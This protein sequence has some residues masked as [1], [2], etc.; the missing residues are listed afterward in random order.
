MDRTLAAFLMERNALNPVMREA[1]D[2]PENALAGMA[3]AGAAGAVSPFGASEH[4]LR[5]LAHLLGGDSSQYGIKS[6]EI[7]DRL[8]E[9][10]QEY[11][12]IAGATSGMV[13]VPIGGAAALGR[14]VLY[15]ANIAELAKALPF[16]SGIGGGLA[17]IGDIGSRPQPRPQAAYPREDAY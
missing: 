15:P 16:A 4:V 14:N 3:K 9:M 10:R 8:Y 7:A 17:N 5:G 11:P 2:P 12:A 13:L 6:R 1:F